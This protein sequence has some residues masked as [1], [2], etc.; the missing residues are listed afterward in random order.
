MESD[1]VQCE[2]VDSYLEPSYGHIPCKQCPK[3]MCL[4]TDGSGV[5]KCTCL[6]RPIPNQG[7]V[8]LGE[9]VS[10]SA[11]S[12]CLVTTAGGGQGSSATYTQIYR[13]L[14][15]VPCMLI[16][17]AAAYC[18]QVYSGTS[19]TPLVVGLALL[20]TSGRRLLQNGSIALAPSGPF[21]SNASGWEGVGEPCRSLV[22]ANVSHLGILEKYT[23]GECWRW[24]DIGVH[25]VAETNM[26]HVNPTFLVSWQDLLNTMLSEGAV[27]EILSRVPQVIHSILLHTEMAQPIY[28]AVLYW[29][30]Y[31]PADMWS[32]HTVMDKVRTYL[33]NHT[34]ATTRHA[35]GYDQTINTHT[36]TVLM[37]ESLQNHN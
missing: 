13:E 15:S 32:N 14:A 12:L 21:S 11:S 27:P 7:C 8:G 30:S 9:R 3:P 18:M 37:N 34:T 33:M 2:F 24:R 1:D 16:N 26:T 35:F 36:Y 23:L 31:L 29:S 4:I 5:G 25:L 28:V 10:P 20:K 19:S 6:L 17:Q 22:S